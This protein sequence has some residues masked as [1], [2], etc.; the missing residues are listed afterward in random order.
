M[1]LLSIRLAFASRRRGPRPPARRKAALAL[2]LGFGLAPGLCLAAP[3]A[4]KASSPAPAPMELNGFSLAQAAV[5]ARE[6]VAGGP[7]RDGI[8]ALT[9]PRTLPAAKAPWGD[10]EVVIGVVVA[11]RARAYPTTILLWHEV[12]NDTLGGRPILVTY[13]PF[14]GTGMVFDRRIQG[15]ARQFG[16]SGLLYHSNMLMYDHETQSLWSQMAEQAITGPSK[17]EHLLLLRSR[18]ARWGAWKKAHPET[19]VLSPDTGYERPYGRSPYGDYAISNRLA[20]PAPLDRRFHPKMPTIG[21]VAPDG[22]ARAYAASELAEAGGS[23]KDRLSGKQVQVSYDPKEE[24]FHFQAPDD[25]Q[26]VE[27]YWFAW[28]AFHPR[29][30]VYRAPEKS[31]GAAD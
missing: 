11:G 26:V 20:F 1:P 19:T 8:P 18:M 30:T 27:G 4:P 17:G 2:A 14:C 3:G 21:M 5:P 29:T 13:G 10:E 12:V 15:Q 9:S 28:A 22:R 25:F 31:P 6:I 23:V 16:V 7:P 24:V